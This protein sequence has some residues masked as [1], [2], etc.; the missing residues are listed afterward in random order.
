MN[1]RYIAI[2]TSDSFDAVVEK[3]GAAIG[4]VEVQRD[5]PDN[6]WVRNDR[7]LVSVSTAIFG[8]RIGGLSITHLVGTYNDINGADQAWLFTRLCDRT[9]WS[10]VQVEY[11]ESVIASRIPEPAA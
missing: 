6:A 2:E 7:I 11:D 8:N 10:L 3:V 5:A 9:E 4:R 1:P